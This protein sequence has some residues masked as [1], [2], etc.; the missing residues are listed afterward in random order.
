MGRE[1]WEGSGG[2]AASPPPLCRVEEALQSRVKPPE[3]LLA[4]AGRRRNLP[5]TW[6]LLEPRSHTALATP[7]EPHEAWGQHG[8]SLSNG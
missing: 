4:G 7:Q 8:Q 3:M 5:H 1:N 6:G 2:Q